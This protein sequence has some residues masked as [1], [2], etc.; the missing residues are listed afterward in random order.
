MELVESTYSAIALR[1]LFPNPLKE[2]GSIIII[3][4]SSMALVASLTIYDMGLKWFV[5]FKINKKKS[6][7]VKLKFTT[8]ACLAGKFVLAKRSPTWDKTQVG[9]YS[10]SMS[11]NWMQVAFYT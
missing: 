5:F 2:V 10:Y 8:V 1:H 11:L 4:F 9:I 3:S 6:I 7:F